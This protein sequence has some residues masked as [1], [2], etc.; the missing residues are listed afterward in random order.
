MSTDQKEVKV[1][2]VGEDFTEIGFADGTY[3]AA[4]YETK[5]ED[6]ESTVEYVKKSDFDA[7][8]KERDELKVANSGC[9]SLS[10]H[11]ARVKAKDNEITFL[12]AKVDELERKLNIADDHIGTIE[13]GYLDAVKERNKK[14]AEI[15]RLRET[16]AGLG[17][18][19]YTNP[20]MRLAAYNKGVDDCINRLN[21]AISSEAKEGV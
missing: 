18:L 10:L 11:E 5:P 21:K 16:I 1:I 8:V 2:H 7:V 20:N 15:K 4:A 14:D 19:Q 12:R 3:A 13:G 17:E 6:D 9:I